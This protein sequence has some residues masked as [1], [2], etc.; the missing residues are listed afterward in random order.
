LVVA[1]RRWIYSDR[2][3]HVS[4][5]RVLF[6]FYWQTLCLNNHSH[7]EKEEHDETADL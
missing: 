7:A 2:V 1:L 4:K 3:T 6:L 5:G